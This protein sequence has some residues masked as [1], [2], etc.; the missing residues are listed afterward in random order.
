MHIYFISGEYLGYGNVR[1]TE[2][3]PEGKKGWG[4]V[5]LPAAQ[6]PQREKATLEG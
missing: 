2:H 5:G 4:W 3:I 1:A 6:R